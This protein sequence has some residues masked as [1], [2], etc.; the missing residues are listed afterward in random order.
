MRKL[1]FLYLSIRAFKSFETKQIVRFDDLGSGVIFLQ[2]VNERDERLESNGA[3]KS[4]IWHALSWCIY[5]KTCANVRTPAIKPWSG[6]KKTR[7]AFWFSENGKKRKLVRTA[8]PNSLRLDGKDIS[9]DEV[10]KLFGMSFELFHNTVVLGQGRPLFFDLTP[11]KKMEMFTEVLSLEKWDTRSASAASLVSKL[12]EDDAHLRHRVMHSQMLID[13]FTDMLRA[14]KEKV[15]SWSAVKSERVSELEAECQKLDSAASGLKGQLAKAE[16]KL[17]SLGVTMVETKR[18]LRSLEKRAFE[19]ETQITRQNADRQD[20]RLKLRT[21]R[22][23]ISSFK[24]DNLCPTCGQPAHGKV[25]KA[26]RAER[27]KLKSILA[28]TVDSK[29]V[30]DHE[31]NVAKVN[32]FRNELAEMDEQFNKARFGVDAK[33][34]QMAELTSNLSAASARLADL[35]G[36]VNPYKQDLAEARVGLKKWKPELDEKT[37]ELEIINRKLERARYWVKGFKN[38]QLYVIEQVLQELEYETNSVIEELGLVG[39]KVKYAVEKETQSGNVQRALNVM[40]LSPSNGKYVPWESW[41]GG[42]AQRLRLAGAL[43]LSHV[44][45]NYAEISIDLEVLD[46]PTRSMSP[47]GSEDTCAYLAYRAKQLGRQIWYVDHLA[48][49][50][51][52]FARSVTVIKDKTGSRIA[53]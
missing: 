19:F 11:Q 26:L 27:T 28:D 34:G 2:G 5:G 10:V 1:R 50:S 30:A 31:K 17:D 20:A 14:A 49:D 3:G 38:V 51:S 24:E 52:R 12:S 8:A 48:S 43:A 22:K 44:L 18:L 6:T 53:L 16:L 32:S 36:E 41:S 21:I 9:Q 35:E 47:R 23:Q 40:V 13:K 46:E 39:W 7:V 33:K 45:L 29:I 42:E 37:R 4:S 25:L 15:N